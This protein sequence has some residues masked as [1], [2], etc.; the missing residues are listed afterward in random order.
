M[1]VKFQKLKKKDFSK[2]IDFAIRGMNFDRYVQNK[3]ALRLYGRY[4]LYL[5][6]ERSSQVISAYMGDELVGILMADMKHEPKQY[7]SIWR[8]A[9]IRIFKSIMEFFASDGADSYDETNKAMLSEYLTNHT[10]DGEICFL[11]VD[12]T[13][14]GKGLGTLL[15]NELS[16]RESNKLIFLYTDSNC[17]Y[18]FYERKGFIRSVERNIK[19]ELGKNKVPL[20]CLLYSKEL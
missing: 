5:E 6:L 8:K 17:T 13:T 2:V 11:A 20:T 18:Q 19:M 3:L 10:P 14:H 16:K 4:F 12:P 9:Y 15:L 7:S 1:D